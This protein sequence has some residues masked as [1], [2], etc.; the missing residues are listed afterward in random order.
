VRLGNW[1]ADPQ[2][3]IF[4]RGKGTFKVTGGI[5][6]FSGQRTIVATLGCGEKLKVPHYKV[7][8]GHALKVY[9]DGKLVINQVPPRLN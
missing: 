5:Q 4:L 8:S 6:R 2:I 1:Y 7:K 3:N 9:K